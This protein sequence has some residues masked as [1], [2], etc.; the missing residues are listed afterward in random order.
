MLMLKGLQAIA[1]GA[2][3]QTP[4]PAEGPANSTIEP[5]NISLKAFVRSN[6]RQ[7]VLRPDLEC[8]RQSTGRNKHAAVTPYYLIKASRVHTHEDLISLLIDQSYSGSH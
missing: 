1:S 2:H 5:A 4:T 3:N 6:L 8:Y 7:I